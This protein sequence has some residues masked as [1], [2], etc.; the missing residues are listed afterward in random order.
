MLYKIA[1]SYSLY[2]DDNTFFLNEKYPMSFSKSLTACLQN[3]MIIGCIVDVK[4]LQTHIR[5]TKPI[6]MQ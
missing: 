4:A 2:N 1:I 5:H 3:L 6:A